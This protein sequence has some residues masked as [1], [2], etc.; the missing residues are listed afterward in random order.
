V[1]KVITFTR[2]KESR[3]VLVTHL[4]ALYTVGSMQVNVDAGYL[5]TM[6]FWGTLD[7]F[8]MK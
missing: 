5:W 4:K 7:S 3:R 1:V 6:D 8:G 2:R